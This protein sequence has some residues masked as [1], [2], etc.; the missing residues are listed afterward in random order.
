MAAF[1]PSAFVPGTEVEV[2]TRYLESWA[3]GFE[4]ASV[5]GDRVAIRRRSDG[6]VLP[7]TMA[8]E[9]VRRAKPASPG[10]SL[11]AG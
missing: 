10:L 3:R 7:V 11:L 8:G 5:E 4:V 9:D 6:V 1:P 2:R